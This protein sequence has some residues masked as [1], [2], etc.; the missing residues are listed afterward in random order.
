MTRTRRL[1]IAKIIIALAFLATVG[2][3]FSGAWQQ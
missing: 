3:I 1:L 2:L